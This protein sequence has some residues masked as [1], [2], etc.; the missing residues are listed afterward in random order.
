MVTK[1]Q[2]QSVWFVSETNRRRTGQTARALAEAGLELYPASGAGARGPGLVLFDRVTQETCDL[3]RHHSR[4]G[5]ERLLAIADGDVRSRDSWRLLDC[6][7]SD[8]L[9]R[10]R[11]ADLPGVVRAKLDRW[12]E[13]D[14]LVDSSE[15]GGKLI[16]R[17]PAWLAVL[18]QVVELA[19]FSDSSALI[20][21]ATG[22]G[23][24]LVA[25]LI[26]S[27]DARPAKRDL[28]VLDCTTIVPE[29]SGSEFFGHKRGAFTNAIADREGAFAAADEGTLFLDEVGD[30]PARLQPELLR[31]VQEGSYK[32]V[33]GNAWR[34]TRF[35]LI[36]ATH[37]DLLHEVETGNFRRDFYYRVANWSIRLPSLDER[38][39]D[40]LPL[41]R[42]FLGQLYRDREPPELDPAVRDLLLNRDYP[43]NVRDLCRLTF[44][45]G[46]R[47][48]GDGPITVGDLPEEERPRS[49]ELDRDWR[50]AGFRDAV[51]HAL[52]VDAGLKEISTAA[53]ETAVGL[54]IEAE[55]GNLKRAARRLQVTERALQLRRA[56]RRQRKKTAVDQGGRPVKGRASSTGS[57]DASGQKA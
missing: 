55:G 45:I 22:T 52:A 23:K 12:R 36:C 32:R 33:G 42:H 28:V 9:H 49:G 37:R 18:R 43:G 40:I 30:L 6:G 46:Q 14:R 16:G 19:R 17:S 25:R 2:E 8:V 5:R 29:L 38:R 1:N 15:V 39:E 56:A 47:H 41:A 44:Q 20:L 7:A 51:R 53:A 4:N 54:A 3:V 50:G 24:E 13:I 27:L 48:V 34:K 21:G 10:R 57:T 11:D 35:R 31:V 26:H